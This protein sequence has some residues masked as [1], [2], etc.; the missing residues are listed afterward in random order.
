ML[1]C[2][3]CVIVLRY[4]HDRQLFIPTMQSSLKSE[5]HASP[6]PRSICFEWDDGMVADVV[7]NATYLSVCEETGDMVV[8]SDSSQQFAVIHYPSGHVRCGRLPSSPLSILSA[9]FFACNP[10]TKSH[11]LAF[12]I[13]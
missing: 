7:P 9:R 4:D 11:Y 2:Q 10:A 3:D 6:A 8:A 12:L 1:T 5:P 13:K